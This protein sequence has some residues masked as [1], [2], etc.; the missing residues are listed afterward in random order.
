[1]K[2]KYSSLQNIIV[3]DVADIS[4]DSSNKLKVT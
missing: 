2:T 1:M 3:K 4:K